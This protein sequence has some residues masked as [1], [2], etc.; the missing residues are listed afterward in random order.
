MTQI[1]LKP[2]IAEL[3]KHAKNAGAKEAPTLPP[4]TNV[5][6][7][8]SVCYPAIGNFA[9]QSGGW[10]KDLTTVYLDVHFNRVDLPTDVDAVIMFLDDFKPLLIADPTL[11]GTVDTLQMSDTNPIPWEF[12]QMKY[13]G[14][15][16]LGLRF[17]ITFKQKT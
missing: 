12:G 3:Q 2:A 14:Q 8:F 11:G 4:E 13:A 10:E 16:T 9:G 6:F 17:R 5:S 1:T 15:E 7:P